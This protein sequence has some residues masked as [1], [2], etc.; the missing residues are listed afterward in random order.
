MRK[1][2]NVLLVTNQLIYGGAERYT[3]SVAN[4]LAS[5]GGRV[6]V[7]SSGGPM[8]KLLSKRVKH[9]FAPVRKTDLISR[10]RTIAT[11]TY[12]S[13]KE[14]IDIIHTQSTSGALAARISSYITK[15]PVVKT[16]HGYP[17]GRFPSVAR[18]LN[19]TTDKVVMISDW[20][21]KR[22]VSFG[23][24]KDKA[25][26]ILNGIDVERFKSSPAN[27]ETLRGKLGFTEKDKVIVSISRIVP[28]KRFE[29]LIYW[30]P[31]VLSKEPNAKLLI[32]GDGG[33][34]GENYREKLLQITKEAR[35]DKAVLFLRGTHK[36]AD[37]LKI[38]DIFCTPSVGKGFAVLEAMA[39]GLPV[40]ARKPRGVADTV[41]DGVNGLL[42]A[43]ND[44]KAMVE[45]IVF[46]IDNKKVA[47]EF[48]KQ[49]RILVS[50]RYTI[51]EMMNRLEDMYLNLILKS[52]SRYETSLIKKFYATS[53]S[54]LE[55]TVK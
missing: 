35:L 15:T 3:V 55:P 2:L 12:V 14:K 11:I 42:F 37:I 43:S 52:E 48:G 44:W 10:M 34:D 6:A 45:Q 50:S 49:G 24:N 21:S 53:V 39:A 23:L 46:L 51:E 28:E 47:K 25:S 27:K 20:L 5:R 19:F 54:K 31:Y 18:T 40:V 29:Q 32:V 9:H 17:E 13:W 41:V 33:A 26:T 4:E 7:V 38:A 30:F 22:L 36:V 16:A 1:R 8:R